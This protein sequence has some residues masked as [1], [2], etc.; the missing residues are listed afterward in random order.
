MPQ[1]K[2]SDA[3]LQERYE[4]AINGSKEGLW[5]WNILTN[6]LYIS[7]RCKEML[8]YKE[9][10]LKNHFDTFRENVYPADFIKAMKIVDSHFSSKDSGIDIIVRMRHKDGYYKWIQGKGQA[11]FDSKGNPY[12]MVG[13]N[14]D[15]DDMMQT[16]RRLNLLEHVYENTNDA[17]FIVDIN[18]S[19]FIDTN[20]LA[21]IQLGYTNKELLKM[22]SS[23]IKDKPSNENLFHNRIDKIKKQGTV[24][25][26]DVHKRKDGSTFPVEIHAMIIPLEGDEYLVSTVRDLTKEEEYKKNLQNQK[27]FLDAIL[28]NVKDGIISCDENGLLK[29]F[30]KSS[31]ILHGLDKENIEPSEWARYYDLYLADAKTPMQMEDI[32]LYKALKNGEVV[33]QEMVIKAKNK[34]IKILIANG[35]KMFNDN[36]DTIGA[37]ISMHDIT[38]LKSAVQE[39]QNANLSKSTFLANM[40]HEIRTPMNAILGFTEILLKA[41]LKPSELQQLDIIHSNAKGLL[42]L[43]ND[44]LDLSKIES[45]KMKIQKESVDLSK[46]TN[47][48]HSLF[49]LKLQEK[50][51]S[52][53]ITNSVENNIYLDEVRLKQIMQNLISNAIKFTERGSIKLDINISENNQLNIKVIDTGIGVDKEQA[54]HIFGAFEQQKG[55][56]YRTFGGTGLGLSISK[57]L[58]N[59]MNGDI[60]IKTNR[61]RGSIFVLE[62]YNVKILDKLKETDKLLANTIEL[63]AISIL[64]VDDIMTNRLLLDAYFDDTQITVL[65]ASNGIEAIEMAKEYNPDLILMDIKMPIMDGIQATK[66]L[67]L[68]P[69]TKHIP[70]SALTADIVNKEKESI[71]Q[72]G[73]DYCLTKPISKDELFIGILDLL[74][75]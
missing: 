4:L 72:E 33:N 23:D 20:T 66:I 13:F 75:N 15:V 39:A 74:K 55:Q 31:K 41:D 28:D 42:T 63:P 48:I 61:P 34:K 52:F 10:E 47:D 50:N 21:S 11:L 22:S 40:S 56:E 16:K 30:N 38:Q 69:K 1:K 58:S 19:R 68:D 26:N 73:F 44:I 43:I 45:G 6:E 5:D 57:K 29:Y 8:G 18:T 7:P 17:I 14:S 3:K 59:L 36:G 24:L 32:P 9:H 67:K 64:I 12:R 49:K 46:L 27:A 65:E 53:S 2:E 25:F 71:L 37:V 60:K 51:L 35:R 54:E 70:I 62:L